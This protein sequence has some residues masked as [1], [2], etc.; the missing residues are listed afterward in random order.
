[1]KVTSVELVRTMIVSIAALLNI[2]GLHGDKIKK[3]T[4]SNAVYPIYYKNSFRT[5][6]IG[7]TTNLIERLYEIRNYKIIKE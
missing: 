3:K 4:D 7:Y 5:I 6:R 2:L 1:M